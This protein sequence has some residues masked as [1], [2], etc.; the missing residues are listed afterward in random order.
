MNFRVGQSF[1]DPRGIFWHAQQWMNTEIYQLLEAFMRRPRFGGHVLVSI[2]VSDLADQL[3]WFGEFLRTTNS[4][5]VLTLHLHGGGALTEGFARIGE[6][7]ASNTS[8]QCLLIRLTEDGNPLDL[9][10]VMKGIQRNLSLKHF[11]LELHLDLPIRVFEMIGDMLKVNT[12]LRCLTLEFQGEAASDAIQSIAKGL[13]SNTSL[14]NLVI[15]R[16]G[17]ILIPNEP[18]QSLLECLRTNRSLIKLKITSPACPALDSIHSCL[19]R[20]FAIQNDLLL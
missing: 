18:L 5:K 12:V 1:L 10:H 7:I 17:Q 6:T 15:E 14:R 4:I 2:D 13:K 19:Q 3:I 16:Y 9:M 11:M 8:L 20:N